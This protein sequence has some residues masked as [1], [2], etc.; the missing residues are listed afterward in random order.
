MDLKLRYVGKAKTLTRRS[1][2]LLRKWIRG[3][4]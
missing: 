4:Y 3:R 2:I 1:E